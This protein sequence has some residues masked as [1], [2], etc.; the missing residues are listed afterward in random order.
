MEDSVVSPV[1]YWDSSGCGLFDDPRK[2]EVRHSYISLT[3]AGI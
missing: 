3:L 1:Y 2:P